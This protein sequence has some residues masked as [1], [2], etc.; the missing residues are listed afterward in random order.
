MRNPFLE[1]ELPHVVLCLKNIRAYEETAK[2]SGHVHYIEEQQ[3]L[4]ITALGL[5]QEDYYTS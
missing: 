1:P 2:E 3:A 5:A 4:S